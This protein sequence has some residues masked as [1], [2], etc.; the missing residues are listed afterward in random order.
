M[1]NTTQVEDL[2]KSGYEARKSGNIVISLNCFK[3]VV[4]SY[5]DNLIGWREVGIDF[6]KLGYLDEAKKIFTQILVKNNQDLVALIELGK[7][8]REEGDLQ[9]AW[10]IFQVAKTNYPD[11]L[12]THLQTIYL[13]NEL[14]YFAEA[15]CIIKDFIVNNEIEINNPQILIG[16]CIA[17]AGQSKFAEI[18]SMLGKLQPFIINETINFLCNNDQFNT[19]EEI[20]KLSQSIYSA[21]E[22]S[23]TIKRL[24]STIKKIDDN[25][26]RSKLDL[27]YEF[28]RLKPL[29]EINTI[30]IA[31][32]QFKLE[33]V[34]RQYPQIYRLKSGKQ[35]NINQS[36][37]QLGGLLKPELHEL[38]YKQ[39]WDSVIYNRSKHIIYTI[40]QACIVDQT[41]VYLQGKQPKYISRLTHSKIEWTGSCLLSKTMK[42]SSVACLLPIM[43]AKFSYY[44][45]L[46]DT[47]VMLNLYLKL[48]L[49][50][51][52]IVPDSCLELAYNL[53]KY[54]NISTERFLNLSA[55]EG[56]RVFKLILAITRVSND[57]FDF[58]GVKFYRDLATNVVA[59][60]TQNSKIYI[61]RRFNNRRSLVNEEQVEN[62]LKKQ[63]FAIYCMEKYSFEEQISIMKNARIIVAPHG[64]GLTN[65]IFCHAG[66][67]IIELVMDK[68]PNKLFY[69]LSLVCRH[70]YYP[71]LG[72]CTGTNYNDSDKGFKWT[73][74]LNK[75]QQVLKNIA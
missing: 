17:L 6:R 42:V 72:E 1:V 28:I 54:L 29:E 9:L 57:N 5:P 51:P 7:I 40:P 23:R 53:A 32:K 70:K 44:H 24:S 73:I 67:R 12:D 45:G 4:S 68:Y 33:N 36:F 38:Y 18:E 3:K 75:I 14:N 10:K 48:E 16:K 20:L 61:S 63:G 2:L 52:I 46:C 66:A 58:S 26:R 47:L 11:D 22:Y 15:E 31:Q 8:I 35:Q 50:C 13:L 34:S 59:N 64:A 71:I 37:D 19:A 41:L 39:K 21:V 43:R 65:I 25:L 55:I 49:N 27:D 30:T 69:E 56:K 60:N 74:D 62:L